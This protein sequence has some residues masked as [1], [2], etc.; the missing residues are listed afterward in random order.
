VQEHNIQSVLE[1][2]CGDGN[3]VS[4]ATYPSYIGFDVSPTA[5]ALC[6]ERFRDDS[7]KQFFLYNPNN[8][9]RNGA[10]KPKADLVLS[11]DVIY[12]LIEDRVFE[13]YMNHLFACSRKYVSI[14]SSDTD[15]NSPTQT[16]HVR[17]RHFSLWITD[18][19]PD[20]ILQEQLLNRF[21]YEGDAETGSRS[22]FFVY[23]KRQ[24]TQDLDNT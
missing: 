3:Q 2:G 15:N 6:R 5:I 22:Q 10:L 21:P 12:H 18:C 7:T 24:Y 17:H 9:E 20:W 16:A 13:L 8:F 19:F 14:Y 23:A 1:F 4:L 11:L